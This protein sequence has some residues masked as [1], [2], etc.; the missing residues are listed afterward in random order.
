MDDCKS[1]LEGEREVVSTKINYVSLQLGKLNS[2]TDDM[3]DLLPAL[4]EYFADNDACIL[5]G[6]ITLAIWLENLHYYM[7]DPNERDN[8][9]LVIVKQVEIGSFLKVYDVLP[10]VACLT[11]YTNLKDLVEIYMKNVPKEQRRESFVICKIQVDDYV[12]LP[13]AWYN[14]QRKSF[15]TY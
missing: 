4:R 9:G 7:F 12:P 5:L 3:L 6:P 2:Q 11:W 10:G 8:N 14:F 15:L 1:K 13:E